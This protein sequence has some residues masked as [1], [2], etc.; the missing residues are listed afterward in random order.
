MFPVV[1]TEHVPKSSRLEKK[2]EELEKRGYFQKAPAAGGSTV[3]EK[4][5]TKQ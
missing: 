3:S 4:R 5:D 2:L 1:V